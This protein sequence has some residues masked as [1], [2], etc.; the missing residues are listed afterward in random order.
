ML[1]PRSLLILVLSSYLVLPHYNHNLIHIPL[2]CTLERAYDFCRDLQPSEAMASRRGQIYHALVTS[3][4][5]EITTRLQNP[6]LCLFSICYTS[7]TGAYTLGILQ[8]PCAQ[9]LG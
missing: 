5:Q 9:S 2:P 1:L 6:R 3:A 4:L 7:N 8:G